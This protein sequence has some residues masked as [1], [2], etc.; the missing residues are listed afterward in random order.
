MKS[1][2][3]KVLYSDVSSESM[4]RSVRITGIFARWASRS[5]VS[6]PVSTT[7]LNAMMSTFCWMYD[8]ID[9]IWFS[10]FCCASENLRVI[11]ADAADSRIDF[12]FAVRQPLSA[13]T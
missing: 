4:A 12:V 13:P 11:P 6:Q 7:G 1:E 2:P 8:R 9:L 10:C 5:T 3:R